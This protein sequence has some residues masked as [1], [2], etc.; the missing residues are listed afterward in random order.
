MSV[1]CAHRNRREGSGI[2]ADIMAAG[3]PATKRPLP[4]R[5]AGGWLVAPPRRS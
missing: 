4:G 5:A 3:S 2:N 1:G